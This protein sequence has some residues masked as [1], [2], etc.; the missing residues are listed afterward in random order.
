MPI[1]KKLRPILI[2]LCAAIPLFAI[3]HTYESI[4]YTG[5]VNLPLLEPF[6]GVENA[7]KLVNLSSGNLS[8]GMA[9][10]KLDIGNDSVYTIILGY[11]AGIPLNQ[12]ASWVGLGFNLNPGAILRS[13]KSIPDDKKKGAYQ[14][15]SWNWQDGLGVLNQVTGGFAYSI[16]VD[17]TTM[18]S[19]GMTNGP[20]G[21]EFYRNLDQSSPYPTIL[22]NN[23]VAVPPASYGIAPGTGMAFSFSGPIGGGL[24][25]ETFYK[26]GMMWEHLTTKNS[27]REYSGRG[28]NPLLHFGTTTPYTYH[29][30][31]RTLNN[32]TEGTTTP[33]Y[34]FS[35]LGEAHD[36]YLV[37]GPAPTGLMFYDNTCQLQL[38]G[39]PNFPVRPSP[40]DPNP[41]P[42]IFGENCGQKGFYYVA[43]QSLNTGTNPNTE[44]EQQGVKVVHETDASGRIS[45]I[46]I[47]DMNGIKY[48]YA[49]QIR[50]DDVVN[51]AAVTE[52]A[53]TMTDD[54]DGYTT[55]WL[56]TAIVY[57]DFTD[58]GTQFTGLNYDALKEPTD[59]GGYVAFQ[60][61]DTYTDFEYRSPNVD[62]GLPFPYY[63]SCPP[64]WDYN[65]NL[66]AYANSAGKITYP[67]LSKIET[68]KMWADFTLSDR[69]DAIETYAYFRSPTGKTNRRK[70]KKLDNIKIYTKVTNALV[71]QID[72]NYDYSLAQGSYMCS[73][74]N[75]AKGRLTL[76]DL[77]ITNK[78]QSYPKVL[79]GYSFNPRSDKTGITYGQSILWDRWGYYKNDAQWAGTWD[80][81]TTSATDA[82]AWSL[83][84]VKTPSG[85]DVA[86][87]YE[88]DD[89]GYVGNYKPL[90]KR[91]TATRYGASQF[92]NWN[93]VRYKLG[94]DIRVKKIDLNGPNTK[95]NT[96]QFIYSTNINDKV[97]VRA[98]SSGVVTDESPSFSMPENVDYNDIDYGYYQPWRCNIG[99]R[100]APHDN[101]GFKHVY[102]MVQ[103]YYPG[104]KSKKVYKYLPPKGIY[105]PFAYKYSTID[106]PTLFDA[107][108][109]DYRPTLAVG[110]LSEVRNYGEKS[111]GTFRE[112]SSM[113]YDFAL[114]VNGRP[115]NDPRYYK[116]SYT[117]IT[118]RTKVLE[119][120]PV[121]TGSWNYSNGGNSGD[122]WGCNGP[123]DYPPC[124]GSAYGFEWT[125]D[126]DW[127][128]SVYY[129][130]VV[131]KGWT[132]T[133]DGVTISY[134]HQTD[135]D[136]LSGT[137]RLSGQSLSKYVSGGKLTQYIFNRNAYFV[138]K[139][140]LTNVSEEKT[141]KNAGWLP[142]SLSTHMKNEF[143]GSAYGDCPHET[144]LQRKTG[145]KK[146]RKDLNDGVAVGTITD[147][148]YIPQYTLTI[149]DEY[150][151]QEEMKDALG[152]YSVNIFDHFPKGGTDNTKVLPNRVIATVKNARFFE[153]GVYTCDYDANPGTGYLDKSNG[154]DRGQGN[155]AGL[156]SPEVVLVA[157]PTHF[158]TKSL[159]VKHAYG[160]T[161]NFR[162]FKDNNGKIRDY[163]LSAWIKPNGVPLTKNMIMG[164]D[165]RKKVYNTSWWPIELVSGTV[166]NPI[167][168]SGQLKAVPKT[169]GW[170]YVEL[171]IPASKDLAN[172]NWND[173][174]GVRLWVGAPNGPLDSYINID[175]IRFYPKDAL[176]ETN[177]YDA[178]RDN[179]MAKV[180]LNG[181]A[182]YYDYDGFDRLRAIKNNTKQITK[183]IAYNL[184]GRTTA[185]TA[186][187][188]PIGLSAV[189]LRPD[190]TV[191]FTWTGVTDLDGDPVKYSVYVVGKGIIGSNIT[192]TSYTKTFVDGEIPST[193]APQGWYVIADDG[194]AV[195]NSATGTFIFMF[196]IF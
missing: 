71:R 110:A 87:E 121:S 162:L 15:F 95:T 41:D 57:P 122:G 104:S 192:G 23:I 146:L 163:V 27:E 18:P 125:C 136:P 190:N 63:N 183:T 154:W 16:F 45:K 90:D 188:A 119:K 31:F 98:N 105:R 53:Y 75:V 156:T 142:S 181:S 82:A 191:K 140:I 4:Q 175:D 158:G 97:S 47:T 123:C 94:P 1:L 103:V 56:L 186:P 149:F 137:D 49:K 73:A 46:I 34:A 141:L 93:T 32:V 174:W 42:R 171:S 24:I 187:P 40:S 85:L 5:T 89:Y 124:S 72:F 155:D 36:N 173:E 130:T 76:K 81:F 145:E 20:Q 148:D 21:I 12:Q 133:K 96:L 169:D 160:P 128:S 13:V 3:E 55:S 138:N 150:G 184:M 177:Y 68:P 108:V 189:Q 113:V 48:Y 196:I 44:K 77:T 117:S 79:F 179:I 180:D 101:Y 102:E 2:M 60:Y 153:S 88:T 131:L 17:Q 144:V 6:G 132:E 166:E 83:T 161:R 178:Y 84:S 66:F 182:K 30:V 64:I 11:N 59:K 29:E 170:Y 116:T 99:Q 193:T 7:E 61:I 92:N 37:Q 164:A 151:K 69:Y 74:E 38:G 159:K 9:L 147:A 35:I 126:F 185:N 8:L 33:T 172:V 157:A 134:S 129:G 86:I 165:Y 10:G 67:Y 54:F 127:G 168:V 194:L 25:T 120:R 112:V 58:N 52:L 114:N 43:R 80:H 152:I 14:T 135:L 107:W 39:G 118:H 28:G 26:Y 62:N 70:L 143:G 111:D 22:P 100:Y 51:I 50:V 139:N 167:P 19:S 65:A 91:G 78:G 109:I 115:S 106:L 195:T 176:V